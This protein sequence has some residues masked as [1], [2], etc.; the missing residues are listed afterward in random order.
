MSILLISLIVVSM[1]A[2]GGALIGTGVWVVRKRYGPAY[3]VAGVASAVCGAL[4]GL[5]A[6]LVLIGLLALTGPP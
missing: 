1:L 2:V 6:V 4:F 5:A 3:H